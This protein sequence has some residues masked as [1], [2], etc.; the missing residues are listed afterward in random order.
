MTLRDFRH[1]QA[2]QLEQGRHQ[3][4]RLRHVA[5]AL[6]WYSAWRPKHQ[7]DVRQLA[8]NRLVPRITVLIEFLAMI[9]DEREHGIVGQPEILQRLHQPRELGVHAA[10]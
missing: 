8:V 6:R 1:W 10:N 3:V 2:A 4:Y 7:R 5:D 9:R